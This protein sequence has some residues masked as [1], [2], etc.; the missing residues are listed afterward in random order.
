MLRSFSKERTAT[1]PSLAARRRARATLNFGGAI[2]AGASSGVTTLILAGHEH[3]QQHDQRRHLQW[4]RR[5]T[6]SVAG[7]VEPGFSAAPTATPGQTAITAGQRC[8]SDRRA[9]SLTSS[10]V[11]SNG[12]SL[13]LAS[14]GSLGNIPITVASGTFAVQ[15]EPGSLAAGNRRRRFRR[16]HPI[17]GRGQHVQHG[18]QCGRHLQSAATGSFGAATRP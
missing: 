15:P 13:V 12:G 9:A 10:P 2:T 4:K 17:S 3:R 7:R 14:G 11:L 6:M 1:T 5:A 16:G 8:K 18:R